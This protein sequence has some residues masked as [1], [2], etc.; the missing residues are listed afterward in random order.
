MRSRQRTHGKA[1]TPGQ[2]RRKI[3]DLPAHQSLTVD[4]EDALRARSARLRPTWYATQKQHWLGWLSGYDGPGAYGRS[5]WD[6]SAEF[7][8]NH[9]CCPPMLVW[10]AEAAG[11]PAAGVRQAIASAL[12]R[13]NRGA[14]C[15]AIRHVIPWDEIEARMERARFETSAGRRLSG[16]KIAYARSF[17]AKLR[18]E[19]REFR[20]P[21]G[22]R[23]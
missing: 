9:I 3:A 8:Y 23:V 7:V 17:A 21:E 19:A 11:V 16:E 22:P 13:S 12:S 6:R 1:L 15:A 14:Q 5:N 20:A 4:Y 2:L 18:D 10:L